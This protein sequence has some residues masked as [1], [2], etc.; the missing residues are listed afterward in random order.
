[1]K[2]IYACLVSVALVVGLCA[3]GAPKALAAGEARAGSDAS[4][5]FHPTITTEGD[6]VANGQ[7]V[8]FKVSYTIDHGKISAGDY[9]TV[10]VPDALKNVSL[11]VSSQVF[12][13]KIDLGNGSYKLVFNENAANAISGSFSISAFG[14]NASDTSK[15]ATVSVGSASK[16]I[17]VGAGTHG[18]GVGPETRGIIKWGYSGDGYTQDTA[19]TGVYDQDKDVS[20]TYAI[21]VDPRMSVMLG[22]RVTDTLPADMTLNPSS[23][24]IVTEYA[25]KQT[26]PELPADEVAQIA[27]V[28]GRTMT[29]DFGNRLDGEK[30]YRIYYTVTVAKGT[31]SKMAN[32]ATISYTGYNGLDTETST[33]TIKAKSGY[34]SSIGYKSVDKTEIGDD[35]ADQTVTYTIDFEN[36]QEFSAG[37]INLVDKLDER[38][39]Y[40][41]SYGSD[42]FSLVYDR[43][44]HS[45]KISNTKPIPASSKQSVTIVTDF[46]RVP[47]GTTIENTVGGNTTKTKKV[48]GSLAFTASKTVDGKQ[49]ANAEFSFELLDSSAQVLQVKKNSADGTVSF[50][51]ISF[52]K[53]DVGKTYV[54]TVREARDQSA[55]GYV[56]DESVYTVR[57]TPIDADGDGTLE[58]VPEITKGDAPV[59]AMTFDNKLKTVDVA[60]SKTWNDDGNRDGKRPSAI[61]VKLLADGIEADRKTVT[62]ADGWAWSFAGLAKYDRTDGHEIDYRIAEDAVEGYASVVRG[63][64]L[65]NSHAPDKTSVTV[66]KAWLDGNDKDRLRPGSVKVQLYAD[67]AAHGSPVVLDEA[68]SWSHTWNDLFANKDGRAIEYTVREIDVAKGYEASVTGDAQSG[69]TITNRHD[70]VEEPPAPSEPEDPKPVDP[71]APE[72]PQDPKPVDPPAPSEPRDPEPDEPSAPSDNGSPTARKAPS[73]LPVTGDAAAPFALAGGAVVGLAAAAAAL[74]LRRRPSERF[75]A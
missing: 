17:T 65:E 13:Q 21:D 2:R 4:A 30:Y 51:P 35:P 43:A 47:A 40:V 74:F 63:F 42:Y 66:T 11:A 55:S 75:G 44:S 34:S 14:S 28:S 52:G 3:L 29:F 38:V 6:S 59:A 62:E 39:T 46:S 24:R 58:C 22:A 56:L 54:Y 71:P 25:N 53:R 64:D 32:S 50:D 73:V 72:K 41:D 48:S 8:A 61:T 10:K 45:V 33:F 57:V 20:I 31:M 15:Q 68:G 16:T 60:G 9:I 23:I 7:Y 19:L 49:P 69:F 37:E 5:Y 12:A 26:G 1:M 27:K 18:G 67:G 36:D 70:P